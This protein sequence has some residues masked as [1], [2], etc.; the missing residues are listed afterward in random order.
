MFLG[1]RYLYLQACGIYLCA[2]FMYHGMYRHSRAGHATESTG[3]LT[4]HELQIA[5]KMHDI[6][7][8]MRSPTA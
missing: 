7:Y 5:E 4:S 2:V 1:A 8:R 3:I 6:N